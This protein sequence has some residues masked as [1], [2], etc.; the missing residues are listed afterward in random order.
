MT[1][2]A[3]HTLTQRNRSMSQNNMN[4]KEVRKTT[5][6]DLKRQVLSPDEI[7]RMLEKKI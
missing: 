6:Y 2:Q 4:E 3:T 7:R 5:D 1:I